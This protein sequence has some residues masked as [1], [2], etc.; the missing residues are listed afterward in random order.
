MVSIV[1]RA[2]AFTA[3]LALLAPTATTLSAP[4]AYAQA[5]PPPLKNQLTGAAKEQFQTGVR[6]AG[7]RDWNGARTSFQAAYDASGNPRVLF[8]VAIAE[9]E[10]GRYAA[11]VDIFKREI[12]EGQGKLTK[13]EEAEVRAAIA[14]L[15]KL[16]ATLTIEVNEPGADVFV[17]SEKVGT[18]PLKGPVT[19]QVGERRVRAAKP[20]FADAIDSQRLAAGAS[21]KVALRLVPIV[22]TSRVNVS[23]VGPTNAIVTVD[24]KEVGP[25]PFVGQVT[26]SAE[27]HQF[28]VEAPGYVPATKSVVVTELPEGESLNV[29]LEPAAEQRMGKL[30]VAARPEGATIEIDGKTVG[31]S[32]WEGPVSARSHQ[33]VVKKPGYYAWS[34]DVDVPRGG[35]RSV[36]AALNEDRNN[37]FVP[38]LI[39]TVVVL[40]A[41]T[42]AAVLIATK[43][44]QEPVN[45]T[46]PPFAVGTQGFRF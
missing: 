11:A 39:G 36:T 24:G 17:D 15:E 12:S 23:V 6:L 16:L 1:R 44:D 27:P 37:N 7:R 40:G 3:S 30:V 31:A 13:E 34:Y 19:V 35:E 32:R 9:R 28:S 25:A 38:W 29:R 33:I 26:V 20:G 21:G 14:S 8:N 4:P 41:T 45:G 46:L 42:V 18:S 43:P 22:K 2:I 10:L 5:K